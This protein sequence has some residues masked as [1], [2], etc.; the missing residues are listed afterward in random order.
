MLWLRV[1]LCE[2]EFCE[3]HVKSTAIRTGGVAP[4]SDDCAWS[5][6]LYQSNTLAEVLV[7]DVVKASPVVTYCLELWTCSL[8][9]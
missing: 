9:Q 8:P 4:S 1:G 6:I 2:I 5:A 7:G 3:L